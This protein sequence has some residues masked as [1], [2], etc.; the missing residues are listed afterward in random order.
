MDWELIRTTVNIVGAAGVIVTLLFLAV[1]LRR[2]TDAVRSSSWQAMQD[3]EQRFDEFLADPQ[4]LDIWARGNG[5]IPGSLDGYAETAQFYLIV[6]QMIDLYQ[7]HHYHHENG[8][9]EDDWWTTWEE[10]FAKDVA[11]NPGFRNIL[12]ERYKYL[13]PSFRKFID[14]F[15]HLEMTG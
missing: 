11:E 14:T 6:K 4:R 10:Q 2:N 12:R 15:G 5:L 3:A 9:I 13:K 7:T 1:Q 8:I